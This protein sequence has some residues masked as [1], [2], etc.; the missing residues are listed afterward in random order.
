MDTYIIIA[1]VCILLSLIIEH[2][3]SPRSK[4]VL[5]FLIFFMLFA[6]SATRVNIGTDYIGEKNNFEAINGGWA[7]NLFRNETLYYFLCLALGKVNN[8]FRIYIAIMSFLSLFPLYILIR[9]NLDN[10]I[11]YPIALIIGNYY[12]ISFSL[13]RQFAAISIALLGTYYFLHARK[14]LG[15]FFLIFPIFIH[16]SILFYFIIFM[17]VYWVQRHVSDKHQPIFYLFLAIGVIFLSPLIF[18]LVVALG[19]RIPYVR[20]YISAA[21][22]TRTELGSGLGVITRFASYLLLFWIINYSEY[23]SDY[24]KLINILLL[25]LCAVDSLSVLY[26]AFLRARYVFFYPVM[27]YFPLYAKLEGTK[28]IHAVRLSNLFAI[29][30]MALNLVQLPSSASMWGNLPYQSWLLPF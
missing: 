21:K 24:K 11:A 25:V 4:N 16:N 19:S 5:L 22:I 27:F 26:N 13:V 23:Q 14:K 6:F 15:I 3:Q 20:Y 29:A 2:T 18:R 7:G 1:I 30:I 8:G 9:K 28:N 17:L 10:R 12:L